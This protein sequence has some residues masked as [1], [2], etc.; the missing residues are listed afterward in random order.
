MQYCAA[1][2]LLAACRI[3]FSCRKV[4]PTSSAAVD[5][6]EHGVAGHT[7]TV[8]LELAVV[9][10]HVERPVVEGDG[11]HPARLA[12]HDERGDAVAGTGLPD[13]RAKTIVWVARCS[14]VSNRLAPVMHPVVAVGFG[15]RVHPGRI[16][17]VVGSVS[18]KASTAHR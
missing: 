15:A 3:L 9:G 2:R 5:L 10:G 14:R 12:R 11:R 8:E 6:A 4:W 16:A 13:V 7:D 17:A 18:P 1:P